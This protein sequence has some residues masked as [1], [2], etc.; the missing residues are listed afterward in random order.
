MSK[1]DIISVHIHLTNENENF[2]NKSNL[3]K[4]KKGAFLINTSRGRIW[5][6]S[7]LIDL[8]NKEEIEVIISKVKVIRSDN[9]SYSLFMNKHIKFFILNNFPSVLFFY[10]FIGPVSCVIYKNSDEFFFNK[11]LKWFVDIDWYYRLFKNKKI[12]Y[13]DNYNV[14]S[15]L[16]HE[17]KITYNIDIQTEMNNDYKYLFK[18]YIKFPM[19]LLLIKLNFSYK[20]LKLKLMS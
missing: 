8:Y 13:F 11:N 12:K 10:N 5:D 15:I 9:S 4:V 1:N 14:I 3:I 6:E 17:G 18:E 19:I 16:N 20:K 2:L 7:V